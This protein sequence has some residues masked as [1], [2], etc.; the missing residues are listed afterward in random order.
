M[1]K[2]TKFILTFCAITFLL[3][4]TLFGIGRYFG[5]QTQQNP[6]YGE[7]ILG[8]ID[9]TV[10]GST[11]SVGQN[12]KSNEIEETLAA[13]ENIHME[14]EC[15]N[16]QIVVGTDY[17]ITCKYPQSEMPE[18]KVENNTLHIVQDKQEDY[19]NAGNI[20]RSIL[21]TIPKDKVLKDITINNIVGNI[22]IGDI[23][24]YSC[25]I[26]LTTG[27]VA[28]DNSE[29]ARYCLTGSTGNVNIAGLVADEC[30]VSTNTGEVDISASDVEKYVLL[31]NVG[32]ISLNLSKATYDYSVK[33]STSVG[34][35]YI[36]G[37]ECD[38]KYEEN[39]GDGN[40][41]AGVNVGD[42]NIKTK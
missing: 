4:G 36:D 24:A 9:I 8:D 6:W 20:T 17:R 38:R 5:E 33:A 23:S 13:F 41:E 3:G 14:A 22:D 2:F 42:I 34:K 18:Y 28:V 19:M 39:N 40:I 25:M 26:T 35:V 30:Y 32:E 37:E 31:S 7:D 10:D 21:I 11:I 16:V 27:N 15:A 29:I 12:E 1:N